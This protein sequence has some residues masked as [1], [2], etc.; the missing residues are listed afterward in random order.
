VLA[1]RR[2]R[3]IASLSLLPH[4]FFLEASQCLFVLAGGAAGTLA[5][6]ARIGVR[7]RA[8]GARRV[9]YGV[10]VSRRVVAGRN[11]T[12]ADCA[13]GKDDAWRFEVVQGRRR[14]WRACRRSKRGRKL[15]VVVCGRVD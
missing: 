10:V 1:A 5:M 6:A 9:V 4:C 7:V 8:P 13:R 3:A 15:G 12:A 11:G 14:T 2:V